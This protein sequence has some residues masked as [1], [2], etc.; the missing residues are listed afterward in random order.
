MSC[1]MLSK[2]LEFTLNHA[3]KKARDRKHEFMTVE[4]CL[5]ALLDNPRRRQVLKACGA[6]M[7]RLRTGSERFVEETPRFCPRIPVPRPSRRSGFS[8]CCS[9]RCSTYSRRERMR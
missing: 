2:E 7:E 6:D 5:L 8:G 9:G 1:Q 3:F 4:H